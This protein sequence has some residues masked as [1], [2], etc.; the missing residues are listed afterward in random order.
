ME[1]RFEE[2]KEKAKK[3]KLSDDEK[4]EFKTLTRNIM[5]YYNPQ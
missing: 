1:K 3:S 4:Q 2:L 5:L